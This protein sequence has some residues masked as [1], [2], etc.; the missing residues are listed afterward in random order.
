MIPEELKVTSKFLQD[1]QGNN[2]SAY[3]KVDI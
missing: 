3:F 1:V 2:I